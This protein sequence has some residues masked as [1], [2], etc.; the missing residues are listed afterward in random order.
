[1]YI[2]YSNYTRSI[3]S[4]ISKY[5]HQNGYVTFVQVNYMCWFVLKL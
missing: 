3:Y 1:M 2:T 5:M 4:N